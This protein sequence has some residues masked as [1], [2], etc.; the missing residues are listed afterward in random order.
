VVSLAIPR[1]IFHL[2][3]MR[4]ARASVWVVEQAVD[5]LD[6]IGFEGVEQV[7]R[8]GGARHALPLVDCW[9]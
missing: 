5:E 9:L 8:D 6:R 7:S 3:R 4:L 1:T 2:A